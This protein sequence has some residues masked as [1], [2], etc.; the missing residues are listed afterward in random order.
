VSATVADR[1]DEEARQEVEA[2]LT[3]VLDSPR[4]DPSIIY[5]DVWT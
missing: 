1:L 2:V 5:K 3:T 4:A